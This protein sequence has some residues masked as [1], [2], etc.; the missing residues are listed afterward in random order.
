M[1][2]KYL[3]FQAQNICLS[4]PALYRKYSYLVVVFTIHHWFMIK[5]GRQT[6]HITIGRLQGILMVA[7]VWS[8]DW[9]CSWSEQCLLLT[10]VA[11]GTLPIAMGYRLFRLGPPA[12]HVEIGDLILYPI[13]HVWEWSCIEN[14]RENWNIQTFMYSKTCIKR[15]LSKRPKM[16]NKKAQ[17]EKNL[18]CPFFD[19]KHFTAAAH[20]RF[21]YK[22]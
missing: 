8:R 19:D 15:P 3:K 5:P 18:I 9:N 20:F 1:D 14:A 22:T 2:K 4:K 7:L 17:I 11:M 13:R 21:E 6:T 10:W 12:E 16:T